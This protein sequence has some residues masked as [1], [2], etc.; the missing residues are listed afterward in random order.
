VCGDAA[1]NSVAIVVVVYA[2]TNAAT[3]TF[4]AF[5]IRY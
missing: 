4:S 1:A 5:V 3:V 2:D